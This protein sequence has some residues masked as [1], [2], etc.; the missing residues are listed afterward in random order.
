MT[1][2]CGVRSSLAS[3]RFERSRRYCFRLGIV[4]NSAPQLWPSDEPINPALP[5]SPALDSRINASCISFA[6]I[7]TS[8]AFPSFRSFFSFVAVSR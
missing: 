7:F 3:R 5:L 8:S 1:S 4:G 6:V 2:S